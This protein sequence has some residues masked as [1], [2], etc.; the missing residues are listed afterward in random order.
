MSQPLVSVICLCY[1][2]ARW[3]EDS[4]KSVLNQ[5]YNNIQL[6]VVDDKSTDNSATVIRNLLADKPQI[7]F[8]SNSKNLGNCKAF[9]RALKEAKGQYIIDLAADD[10]LLPNRITEG[11]NTFQKKD[12]IKDLVYLATI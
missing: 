9:N 8:I 2:Q 3:V 1:N 5:T 6:I 11:V 10:V 7:K 12:T 4:I